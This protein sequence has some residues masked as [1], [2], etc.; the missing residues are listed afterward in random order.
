MANCK[1]LLTALFT[2]ASIISTSANAEQ[3]IVGFDFTGSVLYSDPS[4]NAPINSLVSG[5]FYYDLNAPVATFSYPPGSTNYYSYMAPEALKVNFSGH[6]ITSED[7]SYTLYD[8]IGAN[9]EDAFILDAHSVKLDGLD[10]GRFNL[11]LASSYGVENTYA[12]TS[13]QPP[14]TLNLALFNNAQGNY[15]GLLKNG[16]YALQFSITSLAPVPEPENYALLL[17]GL[18]MI[19]YITR[20]KD[21][22]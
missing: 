13:S 10:F 16:A 21:Y 20:R 8:N 1:K 11:T 22:S 18:G 2:I 15:G 3:N 19:G 12:L 7:L 6:S 5:S 4:L 14:Q 17:A 9:V